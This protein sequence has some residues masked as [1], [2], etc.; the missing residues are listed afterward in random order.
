MHTQFLY[1]S[2]SRTLFVS[3]SR[4]L[5]PPPPRLA[6]LSFL[7]LR[8]ISRG[9]YV[10]C[11]FPYAPPSPCPSPL[12][13]SHLVFIRRFTPTGGFCVFRFFLDLSSRLV[14]DVRVCM[15][16][17][18]SSSPRSPSSLRASRNR[19]RITFLDFRVISAG[20]WH[21]VQSVNCAIPFIEII[22]IHG[23]W[24]GMAVIVILNGTASYFRGSSHSTVLPPPRP[25]AENWVTRGRII[26]RIIN[27]PDRRYRR[28]DQMLSALSVTGGGA[29]G[30]NGGRTAEI[31]AVLLSAEPP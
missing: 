2:P 13:L 24:Q 17:P 5:P 4:P 26:F 23:G 15:R 28:R 7:S 14:S 16:A 9:E 12:A 20:I 19:S 27:C 29:G 8:G 1:L 10:V 22:R 3:F 11:F 21:S 6:P 25:S 30:W 18:S 31:S